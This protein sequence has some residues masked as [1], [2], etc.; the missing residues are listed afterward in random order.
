[1]PCARCGSWDHNVSRCPLP[2][3]QRGYMSAEA[4]RVVLALSATVALVGTGWGLRAKWER[5]NDAKAEQVA[6]RTS[7]RWTEKL[8]EA[9]H[10]RDERAQTIA[11]AASAA[12]SE[13]DRLRVDLR[14]A[15]NRAATSA[16]AARDLAERAGAALEACAGRYQD[17]ARVADE[18]E[19][20]LRAVIEAWPK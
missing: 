5:V 9:Q 20:D 15:L 18:R 11:A 3:G 12:Q 10:A 14:A 17:V 2:A 19:S 7:I 8:M 4:L 6:A 1:M 13:R 16:G